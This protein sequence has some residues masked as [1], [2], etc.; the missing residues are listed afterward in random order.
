MT[1]DEEEYVGNLIQLYPDDT[2]KKYGKIIRVDDLGWTI[3]IIKVNGSTRSYSEG[4]VI[5]ISHSKPFSF[6]FNS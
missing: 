1:Y 5:F 6:I 2:T 3:E 4:D